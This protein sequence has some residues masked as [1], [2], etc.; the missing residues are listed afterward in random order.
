MN[1][2]YLAKVDYPGL[3]REQL[4]PDTEGLKVRYENAA[5]GIDTQLGRITDYLS[6]S[7]ELSNTIIVITGSTV[8]NS[9]KE[10]DG[11][12]TPLLRIGRLERQ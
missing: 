5:H 1:N 10:V 8:K 9:W 6:Q 4:A 2:K 11:D 3:S 7:G 12:I